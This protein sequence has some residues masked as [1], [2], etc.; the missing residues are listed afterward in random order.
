[1]E[2][3]SREAPP[4]KERS[5]LPREDPREREARAH[6]TEAPPRSEE[7]DRAEMTKSFWEP[8][9]VSER[10]EKSADPGYGE[11]S[12]PSPGA[13]R[14]RAEGDQTKRSSRVERQENA[15]SKRMPPTL[16]MQLVSRTPGAEK[17]LRMRDGRV[18]SPGGGSRAASDTV[19]VSMVSDLQT[20]VYELEAR[21]IK[22]ETELEWAKIDALRAKSSMTQRKRARRASSGEGNGTT[23]CVGGLALFPK[24]MSLKKDGMFKASAGLEAPVGEGMRGKRGFFT[25][26]K[27]ESLSRR[28]RGSESVGSGTHVE[29]SYSSDD[30]GERDDEDDSGNNDPVRHISVLRRLSTALSMKNARAGMSMLRAQESSRDLR[31]IEDVPEAPDA[32]PVFFGVKS[33]RS[34]RKKN[35]NM[36]G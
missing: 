20:R 22:A 5:S 34:E 14:A 1:M 19:M 17:A 11:R 23:G 29:G 36:S 26:K 15:R 12:A 13:G 2:S 27:S 6:G 32:P 10:A 21:A 33:S 3:S 18:P 31:G 24:M 28:G 7:G 30:Y 35:A 4:R 16:D 25:R 8:R 9:L